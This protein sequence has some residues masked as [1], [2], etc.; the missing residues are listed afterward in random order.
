[1]ARKP[2]Q[3]LYPALALLLAAACTDG[4]TGTEQPLPADEAQ[5]IAF[6]T[7][8]TRAGE[9]TDA[10]Q[11]DAFRVWAWKKKDGSTEPK[12]VF[13]DES[14]T[15]QTDGSWR[16]DGIK[17]W[18]AGNT[19]DFYALYPS[20][21]TDAQ[22][23]EDGT[24]TVNGFDS[25]TGT[26]LMTAH[27]QVT[28]AV[29][30]EETPGAVVCAF[31]HLLARVSVIGVS[32]GSNAT[33]TSITLSGVKHKGNYKSSSSPQWTPSN[34]TTEFKKENFTLPAYP[35]DI[36]GSLLLIPQEA[37]GITL[38]ITYYYPGVDET[39]KPATL[40]LPATTWEPGK[41]YRYTFTLSGD[42]ILFDTPQANEWGEASG[43][44]II[45]A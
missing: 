33:I 23:N 7:P 37:G 22:V 11:M 29:D 40:T 41:S 34:E 38:T 44:V 45:V 9:V 42:Y 8:Q 25:T 1:M 21:L 5:A 35:T 19:Y 43:G 13:N 15:R 18:E 6:S 14:V 27:E 31:S 32:E 16:Y 2:T 17:L 3:H 30:A 24:V 4:P 12:E 28:Y 39:G 20:D 36:F 26:D 10:T